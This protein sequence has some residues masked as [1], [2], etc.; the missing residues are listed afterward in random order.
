FCTSARQAKPERR[1]RRSP[2][3]TSP[4]PAATSPAAAADG[5]RAGPGLAWSRPSDSCR[6]AP[7]R[8]MFEQRAHRAFR[9]AVRVEQGAAERAS[10]QQ[11]DPARAAGIEML[12]PALARRRPGKVELHAPAVAV[13]RVACRRRRL[14][15]ERIG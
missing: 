3:A 11:L 12:Q 8:R 2:A 14:V 9:F 7:A 6:P 10:A 1:E 5:Y 4:A 13:Q 15:F